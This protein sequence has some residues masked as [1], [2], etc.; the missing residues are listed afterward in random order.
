MEHAEADLVNF[1]S[2]DIHH[3]PG[4]LES[5]RDPKKA[6]CWEILTVR[7]GKYA[8]EMA[9]KGIVLSDE[10]LQQQARRIEFD[11]DDAWN[12]TAADNPEW[13]DLFK[14]AHGLDFI[15]A[16]I[17]GEGLHVPEDLETYGDLGLRVP[18]SVQLKAYQQDQSESRVCV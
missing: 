14:K 12:Q 4:L 8:T 16:A 6:T 2:G 13:L 7:L 15:P 18:F 3:P 10:M 11:S 17:G 9:Q 5:S 1:V